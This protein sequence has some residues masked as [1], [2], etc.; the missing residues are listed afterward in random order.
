M[1]RRAAEADELKIQLS[2]AQREA[3]HFKTEL[4]RATSSPPVRGFAPGSEEDLDS[5][6][7]AAPVPGRVTPRDRIEAYRCANQMFTIG[8]AIEHYA[9]AHEGYGPENLMELAHQFS[10]MTL[11][12]PST[13][14]A[15]LTYRWETF[16]PDAITYE[17]SPRPRMDRYAIHL[18]CKRHVG[19]LRGPGSTVGMEVKYV[20]RP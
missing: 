15:V 3:E 5:Y 9:E 7:G 6:N 11:I 17:F 20:V 4:L 12:C 14:P 8:L 18:L 10:P 1:R 2:A 13:A 19:I 16:P